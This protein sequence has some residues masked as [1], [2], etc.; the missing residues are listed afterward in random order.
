M[1]AQLGASPGDASV[2]GGAAAEPAAAAAQV[3]DELRLGERLK[4]GKVKHQVSV[5]LAHKAQDASKARRRRRDA[6]A[7]GLI[8]YLGA[9]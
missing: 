4:S 2:L 3:R 9:P 1:G 8:G 6:A 5:A 7:A